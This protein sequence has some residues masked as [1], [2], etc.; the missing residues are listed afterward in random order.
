MSLDWL[1][2]LPV[3]ESP[4]MQISS[5]H[6]LSV[7]SSPRD[8]GVRY[9]VLSLTHRRFW[10]CPH[11]C[12]SLAFSMPPTVLES[13]LQDTMNDFCISLTLG[14]S[15]G[16]CSNPLF[17]ENYHPLSSSPE[18][19]YHHHPLFID[20]S[21]DVIFSRKSFL[22]QLRPIQEFSVLL[23]HLSS[24]VPRGLAMPMS[25]YISCVSSTP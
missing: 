21:S 25:T 12:I 15:P 5:Q 7:V 1:S 10:S 24:H 20:L 13:V 22:E 14:L 4:K 9:Q 17:L 18:E 3:S 16:L 6:F 2:R 11:L 8:C 19:P 23:Q